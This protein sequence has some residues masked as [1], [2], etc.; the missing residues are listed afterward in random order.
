M[1]TKTVKRAYKFRF[2]PTDEQ[3][4][5][6][7]RTFGCVRVVWNQILERRTRRYVQEKVST[8]YGD[9]STM[10]TE[11]K[12]QADFEWLN[13]VSSVPLQQALR[14]QSAAFQNFF[15]KRARYPRRKTRK[16]SKASAE[17]TSSAFRFKDGL[18][19][20][21]KMREPLDVAWSRA[22]DYESCKTVTVSRDRAG[23]YFVSLLCEDV[24]EELPRTDSI[25]GIDFGV[26]SAITTSDGLKSSPA[27]KRAQR[28]V[29]RAQR[30]LSRTEKGSGRRERAR[31]R[32]ARRH[33][34]VSD[35]R[36]DWMH[37]IT[38]HLIRDNQAVVVEDL[39]A[40]GM[41]R[42]AHGRGRRAK[43]SLNRGILNHAPFEMRR[44]LEYKADWYGREVIVADRWFPS[45]QICS[46]CGHREGKMPLG[47]RQWKCS[48]CKTIQDRD[49]NAAINLKNVAVG[50]AET[51]NA[52]GGPVRPL[53]SAD[54]YSGS[55]R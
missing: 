51:Q 25:V 49:V 52:R 17:Y 55:A 12:R 50:L 7:A 45:S 33:A 42:R 48:S 31:L 43:A 23:R 36:R 2:Y 9:S 20:L 27:V 8:S 21:A 41:T 22:L 3:A 26:T 10:L 28:K 34:K 38:T 15:G 30:R 14:H 13:E 32:L 40:S 24:I 1:A 19:Y 54:A 35:I 53:A 29:D 44:Q 11:L 16:K 46:K 47:I 4:A 39:N 37:K 18:L 5:E 6:L